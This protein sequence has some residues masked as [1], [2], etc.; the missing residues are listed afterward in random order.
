MSRTSDLK[1]GD[2]ADYSVLAPVPDTSD[3]RKLRTAAAKCQACPLYRNA[4][5]TV[6]G[7]G[8]PDVDVFFIGEQPGDKEDTVGKPFVGP[9]G[10]ILDQALRTVGIDRSKSY[11]TNAVKHFKW[12]PRGKLRIHQKPSSR[13][14]EACRPWLSAEIRSLQPGIIV[15]LGAT[16]VRSA[17]GKD[18]PILKNRRRW[19]TSLFSSKTLITV[20]PSSV[21]RAPDPGAK[22]KA[23][24]DFVA[25]LKV[26]AEAAVASSRVQ[27]TRDF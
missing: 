24:A 6:F 23:W 15:C 8:G 11:V 19:M 20:H 18:L 22:E 12:K 3:L 4:D 14:I 10:G 21:L 25:D 27:D 16:A 26:V 7:E 5:Q 13:E 1:P 9:A 17:F 2:E